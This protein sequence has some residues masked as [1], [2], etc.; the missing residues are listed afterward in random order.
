M[1]FPSF[2]SASRALGECK[3]VG[4]PSWG[5]SPVN[6]DRHCMSL[7][8]PRLSRDDGDAKWVSDASC[9]PR[10]SLLS[11]HRH[12]AAVGLARALWIM[13]WY[14]YAMTIL[15]QLRL[16]HHEPLRA[17]ECGG[18][19]EAI[20]VSISLLHL[21]LSLYTRDAR[22]DLAARRLGFNKISFH[23]V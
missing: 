14:D 19:G 6:Q 23:S 4:N 15:Y 2:M 22:H 20:T 16:Y 3:R 5:P 9:V 21:S 18:K 10:S 17:R 11:S 13:R 1:R 8:I 7:E 12:L